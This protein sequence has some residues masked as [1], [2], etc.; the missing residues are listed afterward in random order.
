MAERVRQ[1]VGTA[2]VDAPQPEPRPQPEPAPTA[3]LPESWVPGFDL[4]TPRA[5]VP[6]HSSGSR[7]SL[8]EELRLRWDPGRR[9]TAAVAA[10]VVVVLIGTVLWYVHSRPHELPV[11]GTAPGSSSA[12]SASLSSSD[13]VPAGG[14]ATTPGSIGASPSSTSAQIVVDVAG[15]VRHPGIYTLGSGARVYDAI[16]AAGGTRPGVSTLSLNLAQPLV[17]GQ[18]VVV[19]APAGAPGAVPIG[20]AGVPATSGS[21]AGTATG[22]IDLNTATLEQLESLPGVGPVLGQNILDYRTAH[23]SFTSVDELQ[24]VTGIGDARLAQ[25]QPLVSV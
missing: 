25:L 22:P 1:L 11:T 3:L 19:G 14:A 13:A 5:P 24:D 10:L 6:R 20:G 18:Q 16:E 4:D 2:L 15:K 17:D 7:P 9:G 12:P 23:G 8:V 21:A